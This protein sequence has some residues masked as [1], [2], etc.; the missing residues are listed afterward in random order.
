[1]KRFGYAFG[2]VALF[3]MFAAP[4]RAVYL[5]ESNGRAYLTGS[6]EDGDDADF[7]A[8]LAKPREKPL[9]IIF[10]NSHGGKIRPAIA[11]ARALRKARLDTAVRATST[12]CESACTLLFAAGIRR[13]NIGGDQVYEGTT[14]LIGLGYHTAHL[15]G[16][17][18]RASE[19]SERGIDEMAKLYVEMGQPQA[20]RLMR[21]AAFNTLWRPSG[22]V[23]LAYRIATSLGE[24]PE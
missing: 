4:A 6:F 21:L 13:Y 3:C 19:Q 20:V 5:S 8:F 24:P 14:A 23:T 2:L 9:K 12:I 1:M 22:Q 7:A 17:R 18:A 11:M 16:D 10:L 15:R